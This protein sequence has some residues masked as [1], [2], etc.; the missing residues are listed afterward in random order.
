MEDNAKLVESVTVS[1]PGAVLPAKR[2]HVT[3]TL[4]VRVGPVGLV[5][6]APAS[7]GSVEPHVKQVR[8][9][10]EKI[11]HGG[12]RGEPQCVLVG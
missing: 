2:T 6:S 9:F 7:L 5:G 8:M 12:N 4:A 11:V 3:P 1:P 10:W